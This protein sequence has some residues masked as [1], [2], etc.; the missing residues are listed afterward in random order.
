[1]RFGW[2]I[3]RRENGCLQGRFGQDMPTT[4]PDCLEA[5]TTMAFKTRAQARLHIE[6]YYGYIRTRPD[7]RAPPN[8]WKMPVPVRVKIEV[9]ED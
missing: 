1:M 5:Y 3:K 8:N 4:V 9:M 6:D 7:L 2:G